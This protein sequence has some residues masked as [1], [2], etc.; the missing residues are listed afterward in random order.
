MTRLPSEVAVCNYEKNVQVLHRESSTQMISRSHSLYIFTTIT[1]IIKVY[2]T[3]KASTDKQF[4]HSFQC[5]ILFI[6][7][8]NRYYISK[9]NLSYYIELYPHRS[10]SSGP[11]CM[12]QNAVQSYAVVAVP[13]NVRFPFLSLVLP[14][15]FAIPIPTYQV[16]ACLRPLRLLTLPLP[17]DVIR[18]WISQ[19]ACRAPVFYDNLFLFYCFETILFNYFIFT[20]KSCRY[21]K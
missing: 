1:T 13:V 15:Y 16:T 18:D 4:Q 9:Y 5:Q 19:A 11:I 20:Q 14:G 2:I 8:I 10:I 12:A 17:C 6:G 7:N 21:L 3:K